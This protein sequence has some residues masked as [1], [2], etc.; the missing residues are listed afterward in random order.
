[1]SYASACR[2]FADVAIDELLRGY[3]KPVRGER[4]PVSIRVDVVEND[5]AY[6][7]HAEDRKSVV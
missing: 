6:V 2:P 3:L 5:G 4:G 7:V 1:M